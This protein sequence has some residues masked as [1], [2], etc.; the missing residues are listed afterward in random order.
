MEHSQLASRIDHSELRPE[1]TARDVVEACAVAAEFGCATVCVSSSRVALARRELIESVSVCCVVGFPS[2]AIRGTIKRL[3]AERAIEDGAEELDMV[4]NLGA[5]FDEKLSVVFDEIALVR[6]A[7]SSGTV[8][9]VIVE[10][11]LLDEAKLVQASKLAVEAGA[12][13]VKTSTG[14]HPSG[15]AT[16]HAVSVIRECVGSNV[17]VKASGGIRDL[18]T[19]VAMVEAGASRLGLSSTSKVLSDG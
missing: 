16:P 10:S 5:F 2:G 8:L 14:F 7:A 9:K 12:D 15:G 4:M 11:A 1:A 18:S 19:A 13:F 6:D 17:G 3:E